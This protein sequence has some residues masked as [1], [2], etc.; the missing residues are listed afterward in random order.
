MDTE[1]RPLSKEG[2]PPT[3]RN[4]GA[5]NARRE[6]RA[7]RKRA[8]RAPGQDGCVPTARNRRIHRFIHRLA[9]K[10]MA[11]HPLREQER[12]LFET[13]MGVNPG[14]ARQ[15]ALAGAQ[16]AQRSTPDPLRP[17]GVGGAAEGP[18]P[19]LIPLPAEAEAE[20]KR[21]ADRAMEIALKEAGIAAHVGIPV[22][23][24]RADAGMRSDAEAASDGKQLRSGDFGKGSRSFPESKE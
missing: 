3:H 15:A 4:A 2:P 13:A 1:P 23:A 12:K 19:S 10:V 17:S 11:G 7:A 18:G 5:I 8:A 14:E 20:A 22:E 16:G 21:R 9:R 24:E 6:R